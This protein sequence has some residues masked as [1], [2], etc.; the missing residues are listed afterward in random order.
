MTTTTTA[1]RIVG[2]MSSSKAVVVVAIEGE[3]FLSYNGRLYVECFKCLGRGGFEVFAG[4]HN[5]VCYSCNGSGFNQKSYDDEVAAAK[6]IKARQRREA[7][8]LA[9]IEEERAAADAVRAAWAEANPVLAARL[10]AVFAEVYLDGADEMAVYAARNAG[11][12]KYGDFVMQMANYASYKGL[13]ENQTVA[14]AAALDTAEAKAQAQAER[15]SAQRYLD[16]DKDAKVV[17]TGNVAVAMTV[18]GY[19]GASTRLVIVEGTGDFAGVTFKM[20]GTGA[21]LWEAEKGD[22]AEVTATVKDFSE[23]NGTKQTVL[24]RAKIKA[25]ATA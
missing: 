7:R 9:K 1:P 19:M 14:V 11:E 12:A 8:R 6:A 3:E 23:Y 25:L 15:V 10:A 13:T 18:D 21:T 20:M 17:V 2:W 16:A 24:T 22:V 4:I 5:G